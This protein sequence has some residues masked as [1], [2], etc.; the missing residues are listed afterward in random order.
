[1]RNQ[2]DVLNPILIGID[3]LAHAAQIR[4][5]KEL[6]TLFVV[7]IVFPERWPYEL[8]GRWSRGRGMVALLYVHGV[9]MATGENAI[10]ILHQVRYQ[11]KPERE[12]VCSVVRSLSWLHIC[13]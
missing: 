13:Y 2:N 11:V 8:N 4:T 5:W 9:M 6:S 7:G 3:L 10:T 1:M 12:F